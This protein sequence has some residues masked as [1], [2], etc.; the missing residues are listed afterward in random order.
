MINLIKP[1][2]LIYPIDPIDMIDLIQH[3]GKI[4]K[5]NAHAVPFLGF[6]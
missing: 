6:Q 3:W 2:N 1:I 5:G 4:K